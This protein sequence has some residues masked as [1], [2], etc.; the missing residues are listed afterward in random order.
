MKRNVW[1]SLRRRA[2]RFA[3]RVFSALPAR[4]RFGLYRR[5]IDF[6][7][8]ATDSLELKIADTQDELEACF[9]LLHDAYVASGF[10]RPHPSGLRVTPYHALPTTTTLCAKVNGQVVGTLSIVREGILGFPMQS[11]FDIASVRAKQGRIAEISAL[12]IHPGFRKTGGSI[13]FPLMKF[14]YEYCT[15]YFDTRHLLIAV[16]PNHIEMYESLLF[17]RR[18]TTD[19]V[20]CYD[21]ANG[22]PAIGATL[23]LQEAPALFEKAYSGKP[24]RRNL[25]R[26]FV[27]TTLPAIKFPDRPWHISNDPVLT[28]S[29]MHYFF[30]ARTNGFD[31]LDERKRRLLH[32]MYP[33]PEWAHVLPALCS[34]A[35][36]CVEIR[37]HPR[38]SLKFPATFIT[39]LAAGSAFPAAIVEASAR[40]FQARSTRALNLGERV[41]ADVELG[42]GIASRLVA[43][44]ARQVSDESGLLYGFAI[45]QNDEAWNRCVAWLD[46][47][48]RQTD[49]R[50]QAAEPATPTPEASLA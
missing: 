14:M 7:T 16:N 44:V 30:I 42:K 22:A 32:S 37:Q 40:G 29:L 50:Q 45:E 18:L 4:L 47:A 27:Y 5:A 46:A 15:Q 2:R 8:I 36:D 23:D 3:R 43:R 6:D 48:P 12:A 21:F 24:G 31:D 25:H 17:F 38:F 41:S 35:D 33:G 20:A 19:G 9:A 1:I 28:P 11:A 34:A 26:F 10:M 13:L 49:R 39:G